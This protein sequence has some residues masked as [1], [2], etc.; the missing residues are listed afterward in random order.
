MSNGITHLYTDGAPEIVKAGKNLRICQDTSAPY[1]FAI[2]GL[3]ERQREIKNVLEG[4]RTLLE[5]SGL[6][7]PAAA[8]ATTRIYAWWRVKMRGISVISRDIFKET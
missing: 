2:N 3:A 4:T 8:F 1:R 6:P 5:H 7:M